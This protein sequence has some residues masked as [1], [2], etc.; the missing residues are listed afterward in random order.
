M[1]R[2]TTITLVLAAGA[3]GALVPPQV[4]CA[5]SEPATSVAVAKQGSYTGTQFKAADWADCA[6][7]RNR[8]AGEIA[9]SLKGTGDSALRAFISAPANRLRLAQ[10][11]VASCGEMGPLLAEASPQTRAFIERVTNDLGWMEQIAYSGECAHTGQVFSVLAAIESH[12]KGFEQNRV[13]RDIATATAL[14]CAR[15]GANPDQAVARAEFYMNNYRE[16]RFHT[17]FKSLPFWQYRV[18][19]GC[20]WDNA[21]GS[22]SSLQWA[23][24]NV[25]LPSTEYTGACWQAAYLSTNLF[26]DSIHGHH[27]YAPYVDVFGDNAVHR[28]RE[29]GGVCGSLSHYG[30]FAAIA[31]GVPAL[32]A[33][34][35]G[36]C[37]YIVCVD[38]KWVPSYSL[39]WQ[40]GLHWQMWQGNDK[41]SSL[42]L[43][44]ELFSPEQAEKT[45]RSESLRSLAELF[46]SRTEPEKALH[47]FRAATDEQ[48]HNYLAWV[49]YARF[50]QAQKPDD[51]AAWKQLYKRLSRSMAPHYPE[52]AAFLLLRHIHAGMHRACKT[53]NERME[54]YREFWRSVKGMGPVRWDVEGLCNSQAGSLQDDK[55]NSNE[56]RLTFYA[57]ALDLAGGN[58]AY[59]PVLVSWGNGVGGQ[60]GEDMQRR[61]LKATLAGLSKGKDLDASSRDGILGEA[62][63]GAERMRDRT[64][65]QAVGKLLS[66]AYRK[67]RLPGWQ[68]YPGKL[69]S[70]GG[71]IYTSSRAHDNAAEHWGVLEPTGGRFHTASET[72]PW[73]VVELPK[74][75]YVTGVVA[76][77]TAGWNNRRLEGM[78]V[79]FSETGRDGDW[80]DA[81][82]FPA[83][84]TYE[85]NRLDLQKSKPRARFIR[86]IRSGGPDVFHLNGIF[87]YG[88][89]AA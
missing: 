77:S 88:E 48:P 75:A 60:M 64:S 89:P 4:L 44:S 37:A 51:A 76:I 83:P 41:Y 81:G 42:H 19:C 58:G 69:V 85:V 12:N 53:H 9:A 87:V 62:L 49:S 29:V 25:H 10:W 28:S 78:K 30:A 7:L 61:F 13:L 47:C 84:S 39:S 6:A 57:M 72:N 20:K 35:P 50:L 54:C 73:V 52:M 70:Q 86:I 1:K 40:R 71:M 21:N 63:L 8:L 18:I 46:A 36:H 31:N 43:A 15:A 80:H 59:A 32:T 16:K 38:G 11:H 67:P 17:G 2:R 27:Y 65:F 23:L 74:M 56:A 68:A 26:G 5:D 66:D 45:A 3:A 82:A 24:D 22:I 14:E 79:Q 34:E 55:H 33:G